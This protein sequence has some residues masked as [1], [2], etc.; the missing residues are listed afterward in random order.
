LR[1]ISFIPLLASRDAD[2]REKVN[3][4]SRCSAARAWMYWV[5]QV[6]APKNGAQFHA[7]AAVSHREIGVKWCDKISR[8]E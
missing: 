8:R 2:V 1:C 7:V 5:V 3:R 6:K 4:A